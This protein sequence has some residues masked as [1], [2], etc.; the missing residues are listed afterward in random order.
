MGNT[1]EEDLN[2][3]VRQAVDSELNTLQESQ[4]T[5]SLTP[6]CSHLHVVVFLTSRKLLSAAQVIALLIGIFLVEN[7]TD[8]DKYVSG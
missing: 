2:A 4:I 3:N 7:V 6:E 5:S 1:F 8:C